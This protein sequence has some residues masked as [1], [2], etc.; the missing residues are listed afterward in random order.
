MGKLN[1]VEI[2]K[3]VPA[4]TKL[5]SPISG[6]V[7]LDS[8]RHDLDYPIRTYSVGGRSLSL[9]SDGQFWDDEHGECMLFPSKDNRDWNTFVNFKNG[10]LVWVKDDID[11]VWHARYFSHVENGKFYVY[12]NQNKDGDTRYWENC[13]KFD[14]RPF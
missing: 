10:E 1:L 5:Y 3:D 11:R 12:T 4:G 7:M 8:I 14:K 13:V 2:L 9:T 6:D